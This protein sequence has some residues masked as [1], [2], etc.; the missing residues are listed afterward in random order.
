MIIHLIW[1]GNPE[2]N[3]NF[4]YL[5]ILFLLPNK[6]K[7]FWVKFNLYMRLKCPVV[8][9]TFYWR[10]YKV[11]FQIVTSELTTFSL[12]T[13]P[14]SL[15]TMCYH[16]YSGLGCDSGWGWYNMVKNPCMVSVTH[17]TLTRWEANQTT[18]LPHLRFLS[19]WLS[20]SYFFF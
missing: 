18:G 19:F 8:S 1:H 11:H 5:W 14:A 16:C 4:T 15:S 10:F 17:L 13:K 7:K 12:S 3:I 9:P 6:V 2:R 20:M